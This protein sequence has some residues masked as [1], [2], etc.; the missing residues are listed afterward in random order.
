SDFD[1]TLNERGKKDAPEMAHRIK[2]YGFAP[3]LIICSPAKRTQKT[4]K[5]AAE[6]LGLDDSKF[7]LETTMYDADI[8]DLLFTIRSIDDKRHRVMMVGHNPGFT[9]L[10][11][12]LTNSFIDNLPTSG[13]ALIEFDIQSW[14]QVTHQSGTLQWFDYPKNTD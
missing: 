3:Q 6:V 12:T 8:S 13:V 5:I 14:K 9:G 7:E 2:K 11:G 10:I 1:R 4:A